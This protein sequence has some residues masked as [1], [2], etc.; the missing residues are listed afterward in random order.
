[1]RRR[2]LI[3]W[4]ASIALGADFLPMARQ[5]VDARFGQDG[6][7]ALEAEPWQALLLM[8]V[9]EID[10]LREAK[11][12]EAAMNDPFDDCV[13]NDVDSIQAMEAAMSDDTE[14]M[15]VLDVLSEQVE[16]GELST[17]DGSFTLTKRDGLWTFV[18]S[19]K[20]DG[21]QAIEDE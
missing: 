8:A 7:V 9:N 21:P 16:G 17:S 1:M 10:K 5:L 3:S 20:Y 4:S 19:D 6:A 15:G 14:H 13:L 12:E 11:A 18:P 2:E